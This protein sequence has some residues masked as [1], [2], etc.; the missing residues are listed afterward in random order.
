MCWSSCTDVQEKLDVEESARHSRS[1]QYLVLQYSNPKDDQ[2]IN[3]A[4][5]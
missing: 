1:D 3:M 5:K 2:H 4:G